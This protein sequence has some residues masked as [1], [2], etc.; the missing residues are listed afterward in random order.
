M[1]GAS[2]FSSTG[3]TYMIVC[4]WG[5]VDATIVGP[6]VVG[7]AVVG[8]TDGRVE[9]ATE[10]VGAADNVGDKDTEGLDDGCIENVGAS[11][12]DCDGA[13]VGRVVGSFVGLFVGSIVGLVVGGMVLSKSRVG[14]WLTDPPLDL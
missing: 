3:S 11:V 2:V 6:V 1:A 13:F 4:D 8:T 9:G 7:S 5:V 12:G 14:I 10:S